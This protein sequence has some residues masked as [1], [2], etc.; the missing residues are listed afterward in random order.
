M[1]LKCIVLFDGECNF[2]NASVQFIIKRD[3]KNRFY[4]ASL[5][6]E[7]GQKLLREHNVPEQLDS[8]VLFDG[9]NCYYQST[10]A[11]RV[12]RHLKGAYK[13]VY[14]FIIIPKPV[15]NLVYKFIAKNRY[16]WFGKVESCLIPTPEVKERFLS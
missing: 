7:I 8:F 2:C 14:S 13:L 15:R 1:S 11:L 10:A 12:C 4:F 3:I 9:R 6:S 5:Q 16:K